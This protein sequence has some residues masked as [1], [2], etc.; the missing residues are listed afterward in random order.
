MVRERKGRC[1][2]VVCGVCWIYVS[3]GKEVNKK[4]KVHW[5]ERVSSCSFTCSHPPHATAGAL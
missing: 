1:V 4:N 2:W 3:R 5:T